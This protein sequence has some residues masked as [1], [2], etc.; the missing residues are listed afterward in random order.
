MNN[1]NSSMISA[2]FIG[3]NLPCCIWLCKTVPGGIMRVKV[4]IYQ[5]KSAVG[6][7]LLT[8]SADAM[9]CWQDFRDHFPQSPKIIV[10]ESMILASISAFPACTIRSAVVRLPIALVRNYLLFRCLNML[11]PNPHWPEKSALREFLRE[12]FPHAHKLLLVQGG[13]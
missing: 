8:S 10:P 9:A 12:Y 2:G 13:K 4:D 3:K 11:F 6:L 1:C 5:V 7:R